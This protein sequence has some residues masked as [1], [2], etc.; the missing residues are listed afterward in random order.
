M[1]NKYIKRYGAN[2]II[3]ICIALAAVLSCLPLLSG[4]ELISLGWD[5]HQTLSFYKAARES[6]ISYMQMPFRTPYF[7]G[8]YPLMAHPLDGSLNPFFLPPLLFGENVGVKINIIIFHI[9]GGLGMFYL[10]RHVL[11]QNTMGAI[12]ATS[13]FCLGGNMH[14]LLIAGQ[15]YPAGYYFF[16]PL[17]C[18]F[19]IKSINKKK[20][21]F[22][23]SLLLALLLTQA[24]LR[25]ATMVLFL[26][27]YSALESIGL[28]QR[29]LYF[30][31]AALRNLFMVLV[32]S[33]LLAAV[34][35]LPMSELLR[36]APRVTSDYNPFFGLSWSGLY[37]SF[38]VKRQSFEFPGML[39]N[40]NYI[41]FLPPFVAFLALVFCFKKVWRFM[42]LAVIFALLSFGAKTG[43]DCFKFLHY[44]PV[45][46][47]I[48][49]PARYFSP[50]LI[51]CVAVCSGYFFSI[52]GNTNSRFLKG[53]LALAVSV[54]TLDLFFSG[55][56]SNQAFSQTIP[57]YQKQKDFYQVKNL[58]AG[59]EVG[60]FI[61]A[62]IYRIRSWEWTR[63]TQYELMLQNI[64]K[65]NAYT[66]LHLK[67]G[68]VPRYYVSWDG[69]ESMDPLSYRFLPNPE[70]KGELYFIN[71]SVS[72]FAQFL[73]LTPNKL[74][75]RIKL[76]SADTL[77]INQNYHRYW[78]SSLGR[79][80]AYEGLLAIHLD[81]P[82]DYTLKLTY[83]PVSFYVGLAVSVAVFFLFFQAVRRVDD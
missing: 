63:P 41:G 54:V 55:I 35:L 8:G 6:V 48:E 14:R 32:F 59:T 64:G 70:Y 45:F 36:E 51:F 60:T 77:V 43:L 9:V 65:I 37:E 73:T 28:R 79:V 56:H 16:L 17:L 21:I 49:S 42:V 30:E 27:V 61:P 72:N 23:T 47:S 5:W 58:K 52:S 39:W 1:I 66:N 11:R 69:R 18:A 38:F 10:A 50:L 34:K 3:F 53:V 4:F 68:A 20:F 44:L 62:E 40:Y 71:D 76:G 31:P 46:N 82:G 75:L 2:S 78:R 22:L 24:G 57:V 25:F 15:T 29:R 13:V 83:V 26:L 12:F 74:T 19:F 7:D 81:K 33:S 67:I 80:F